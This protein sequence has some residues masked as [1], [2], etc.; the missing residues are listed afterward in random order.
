MRSDI[1]TYIGMW[2]FLYF[3]SLNVNTQLIYLSDIT[4][5]NERPTGLNGHLSTI[6]HSLTCQEISYKSNLTYEKK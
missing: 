6:A 2:Y 5:L 4:F 3:K 1:I